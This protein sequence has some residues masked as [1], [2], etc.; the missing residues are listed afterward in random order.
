[1]VRAQAARFVLVGA[2]T[3]LAD[4]GAYRLLLALDIGISPAKAAGF[5]IGTTLSY[6]L[7]RAWTFGAAGRAHAVGRFVAVYAVTLV[8]N[9]GVNAVAVAA[10]TGVPGRITVAWLVAQA[11]ASLLNFL[12]MRH[13]VFPAAAPVSHG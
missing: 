10:L 2:F 1:M 3:A 9:V 6:L 11:I 7:N 13:F 5:V 8:V 4:Y 12:G